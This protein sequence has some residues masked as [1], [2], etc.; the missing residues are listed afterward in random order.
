MSPNS[1]TRKNRNRRR[2][3]ALRGGSSVAKG[4]LVGCL[5]QP[6]LFPSMLRGKMSYFTVLAITPG[7]ASTAITNVFRL[8]SVYDPDLTGVGTSA[9]GYSQISALYGRYRVLG[10]SYSV[11]WS[12]TS[13]ANPYTAFVALSPATT[14]GTSLFQILAQRHVWYRSGGT[15]NAPGISHSGRAT[16]GKI[17]GVPE[18][19]V[20]DEDDFAGL[21]GA[22][23]NNG[24]YL[25]VGA[26]ADGTASAVIIHVRI[27][28]D[29]VWSL[30][31]EMS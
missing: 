11:S 20:R 24:V 12:T 5:K 18:A 28:Y 17:Y 27:L 25:H 9:V 14:V 2:P 21:V 23:P 3:K 6:T 29:V 13:T 22:N 31:L 8:N 1:K 19:Q 30:P 16:V 7:A 10:A 26:Y 15:A 4:V